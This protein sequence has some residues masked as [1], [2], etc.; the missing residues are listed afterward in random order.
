MAVSISEIKEKLKEA[1]NKG[2]EESLRLFIAE[3]E[4]DER[5]GV[6]KLI[7][8]AEKQ[9]SDLEAERKRMYEMFSFERKYAS[10]RYICGID[11]VGRGPLAGPV[12][13][14][15]VLLPQD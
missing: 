3:F 12:V 7:L 14:A 10:C 2:S 5:A 15:A 11:E 1:G 8:S 13:T 9:I 6:K 4:G